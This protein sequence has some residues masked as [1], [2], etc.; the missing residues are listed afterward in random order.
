LAVELHTLGKSDEKSLSYNMCYHGN[1]A[2]INEGNVGSIIL[3]K[4]TNK[5]SHSVGTIPKSNIKYDS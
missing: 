3:I 2:T 1:K 5:K 4:T